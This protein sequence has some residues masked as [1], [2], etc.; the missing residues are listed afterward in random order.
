MVRVVG[1]GGGGRV[2]A[3]LS[4]QE[5]TLLHVRHRNAGQNEAGRGSVDPRPAHSVPTQLVAGC[6]FRLGGGGV[7]GLRFLLPEQG[8][9]QLVGST[10]Q[11]QVAAWDDD[12]RQYRRQ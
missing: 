3:A 8:R 1:C 10:V 9:L 5:E 11:D 6:D 2:G 7:F 12:E 4:L